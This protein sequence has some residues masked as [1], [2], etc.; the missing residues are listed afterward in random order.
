MFGIIHFN[1][2][3]ISS[4]AMNLTPGSDTI[5][6]LGNSIHGKKAGIYS[7][8]GIS[9]GCLVHTALAALGL[10][11]ILA[12]S[13]MAFQM[14]KLAGAAYLIYIGFKTFFTK[15]SFT[16]KNSLQNSLSLKQIYFR[17]VTTNILNPKVALFYLAFLPQFISPEN[18]YNALPFLL[19]G[20]SFIITSTLWCI[21]LALF[22]AN[23]ME[24]F[25][26]KNQ[27][28]FPLNKISGTIFILLGLSLLGAKINH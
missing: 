12:K 20:I 10:S 22:S 27:T 1:T 16:S 13:A 23:L 4:V 3:L 6:I 26:N 28:T 9:T 19:L 14:L 25:R 21:A 17:G 5:Y 24:Y 15:S 18:T 7:A 8:L 11:V 2:F